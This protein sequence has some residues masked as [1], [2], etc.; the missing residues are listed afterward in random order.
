MSD[1]EA[2][3]DEKME[4]EKP[5]ADVEADEVDDA[6]EAEAAPEAPKEPLTINEGVQV[7]IAAKQ[8]RF[9]ISDECPA[10]AI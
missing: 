6:P 3:P 7:R 4:E 9:N 5:E 1:T 2:K 10:A 8:P